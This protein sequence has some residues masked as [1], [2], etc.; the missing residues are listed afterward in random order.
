MSG[1]YVFSSDCVF[2]AWCDFCSSLKLPGFE[3]VVWVVWVNGYYVTSAG[4]LVGAG[5][6]RT[7]MFC[8][9]NGHG[10]TV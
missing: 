6:L 10:I 1:I 5:L 8:Q 7:R 4:D 3:W 9:I 2:W